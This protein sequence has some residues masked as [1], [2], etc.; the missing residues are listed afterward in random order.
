MKF[1][2]AQSNPP[3]GAAGANAGG[4][5]ICLNTEAIRFKTAT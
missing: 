3:R 2:L 1:H 4:V 5:K